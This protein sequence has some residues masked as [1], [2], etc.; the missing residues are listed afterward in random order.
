MRDRSTWRITQNRA[1][2]S[3]PVPANPHFALCEL[4]QARPALGSALRVILD[5]KL[6]P[7][8]ARKTFC[9]SARTRRPT[10]TT[11]SCFT[12]GDNSQ[13]L[14]NV[15][16]A[17]PL[18]LLPRQREKPRLFKPRLFVFVKRSTEFTRGHW[19]E[20]GG[21]TVWL[22]GESRLDILGGDTSSKMAD[23]GAII[24]TAYARA[25]RSWRG[26]QASPAL[27][28]ATSSNKSSARILIKNII[29]RQTGSLSVRQ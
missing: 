11:T 16:K 6:S 15:L 26:P 3:A 12:G 22:F 23:T 10:A 14:H 28:L 27:V 17:W 18:D 25:G 24:S 19:G 1:G 13:A 29:Q 7:T 2:G 8:Q 21:L 20:E 5:D 9:Q 4:F